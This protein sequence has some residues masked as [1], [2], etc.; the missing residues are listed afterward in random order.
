MVALLL[1]FCLVVFSG[2]LLLSAS[3]SW[4]VSIQ[5]IMLSATSNEGEVS[6]RFLSSTSGNRYFFSCPGGESAIHSKYND[7]FDLYSAY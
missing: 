3:T 7:V 6:L 5:N 2:D 4:H 1:C